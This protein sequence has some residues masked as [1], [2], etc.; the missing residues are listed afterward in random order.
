M[1]INNFGWFNGNAPLQAFY[2]LSKN[3]KFLH[4]FKMNIQYMLADTHI[5]L[6]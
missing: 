6:G 1:V 4:L 5:P 2:L 3:S